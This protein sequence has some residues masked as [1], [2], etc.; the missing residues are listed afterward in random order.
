V[1]PNRRPVGTVPLSVAMPVYNEEG[2]IAQAVAE[3]EC[4]VLDRVPGSE[5][6]AVNDGSKDGTARLLDEAAARNP[7]I[8][9]IHQQNR[10]HGGALMAALE[11]ANGEYLFLID[12]DRQ[13]P[14]DDFP[15][16]WALIEAG[17]DGVFGERRRRYDPSLRLQ[18]S[19]II[20]ASIGILFGIAIFDANVPYKIVR[21]SIWERAR[22]CIPADTLAPSL[23]LAIFAKRV[24]YAIET[25]EVFHKERN[26][27]EVSIRRMKL[28]KFCVRA[29]RQ[30]LAFRRCLNR[31]S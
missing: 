29:F 31:G 9:V 30:L 20:R 23:F 14:L 8:R 4:C 2:A 13:I 15:M 7:R 28:V 22:A 17:R 26:T 6:V 19:K 27:G 1:T 5:L 16:A 25:V 18:L 24:G 10:G 11:A 12:S 3:I 21:R